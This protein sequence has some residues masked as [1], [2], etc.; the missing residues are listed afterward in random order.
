MQHARLAAAG[1]QLHIAAAITMA[2]LQMLQTLAAGQL[3][4]HTSKH[5]EL[6]AAD[7]LTF[8]VQPLQQAHGSLRIAF[9]LQMQLV[10]GH[11]T[12][13]LYSFLLT[14]LQ[15]PRRSGKGTC[16][17]TSCHTS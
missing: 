14:L 5:C 9:K 15:V 11:A 7:M 3:C 13:A 16:L 17:S 12:A 2:D 10:S 6:D 4:E 8:A 1:T